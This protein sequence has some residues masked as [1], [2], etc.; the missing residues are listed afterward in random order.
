[1]GIAAPDWDNGVTALYCADARQLPLA[2]RSVDCVVTS[3]PYYGHRRYGSSPEI[4]HESSIGE[5]VDSMLTV[6]GELWRVLRDTGTLWLVIGETRTGTR[7]GVTDELPR[8]NLMG[9]PWRLAL[10]LQDAGWYWRN[11]VIWR[12]PNVI[13]QSSPDHMTDS[14][15]VVLYLAKS[16]GHY[17]DDRAV[18][19][20]AKTDYW[21]GIGPKHGEQRNRR[22]NYEPMEVHQTVKLRDV[23]DIATVK[24]LDSHPAPFPPE[25]ARRC[26]LL[27][28]PP[29]GVVLDPFVGSGTTCLVAQE[30]GRRSIGVD[31]YPNYIRSAGERLADIQIPMLG[32]FQ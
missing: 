30:T 28:C 15:E 6:A 9:I 18:R 22:E 3:P 20:P 13:P 27:G 14:Y 1:M 26:I 8:K 10:A 5:Y 23:W 29:V 31:L 12:K 7:K 25:L 11:S 24:G 16:P 2:D 17:F 21:P 19:L 4:G 32:L